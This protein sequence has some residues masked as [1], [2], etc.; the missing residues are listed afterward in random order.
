[1]LGMVNCGGPRGSARVAGRRRTVRLLGAGQQA[2]LGGRCGSGCWCAGQRIDGGL[3][4]LCGIMGVRP[5][6]GKTE[7][8][9]LAC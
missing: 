4:A 1:M 6:P 5:C 9:L 8:C 2:G 7:S 3:W